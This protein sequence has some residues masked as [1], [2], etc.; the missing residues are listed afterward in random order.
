MFPVSNK[1]VPISILFLAIFFSTVGGQC[2][3][4]CSGNG[5]CNLQGFC[6]CWDGY[7]GWDCSFLGCPSAPAWADIASG[8]DDAHNDAVCSN[9]GYCNGE[10][11][12]CVCHEGF[13]GRACERMS[14]PNDCNG[15]GQCLSM[16]EAAAAEDGNRLIHVA[17]YEAWD[18]DMI[19]GC[20]CDEGYEG[21][22]CSLRPCPVSDSALTSGQ[23]DESVVLFCRC[24][25][26][27]TNTFRLRYKGQYATISPFMSAGEV[28]DRIMAMSSVKSDAREY[29]SPPVVAMFS[30]AAT[31][32]SS[33]GTAA[34]ITFTRDPGDL[35]PVFIKFDKLTSSEGS[36][37][38]MTTEA[39]LV[40]TCVGACGGHFRFVGDRGEATEKLPFSAG[41]SMIQTTLSRLSDLSSANI[42][43][44]ISDGVGS[45]CQDSA[46]VNTTITVDLDYGNY[47]LQIVPSLFDDGQQ[48]QEDEQ[49]MMTL[50]TNDGDKEQE[51]CA[52]LGSCD[53][54][55]G[56]CTCDEDYEYDQEY[57][58][59]GQYVVDHSHWTGRQMCPGFVLRPSFLALGTETNEW[60]LYFTD[61]GDN[62]SDPFTEDDSFDSTVVLPG[63]YWYNELR[64]GETTDDTPDN[65]R[66]MFVN[67]TDN[68]TDLSNALALDMTYRVLY[69]GQGNQV[70]RIPLLSDLVDEGIW[71]AA[72]GT[73]NGLAEAF[74]TLPGYE[75]PGYL[76]MD[77]RP[78]KR[79]LYLTVP[80]NDSVPDGRVLRK[81]LSNDS[82]P[83][84][85]EDLSG[86]IQS[87]MLDLGYNLTDP[88]GIALDLVDEKERQRIYFV[89]AQVRGQDGGEDGV[90][91]RCDLDGTSVE[92]AAS[93]NM[94]DPRAL[95]LDV[96]LAVMY[97]TDTHVPSIMRGSMRNYTDEGIVTILSGVTQERRGELQIEDYY[98]ALTDPQAL[99]L[100]TRLEDL[101]L[102]YFSDYG[103][104]Y[105]YSVE[106]DGNNANALVRMGRPKSFVFDLGEGYPTFTL[107]YD[108]HG[109]GV[110]SGAPYFTCSCDDGWEGN[111][112]QRSCPEGPAWFDEA[113]T[114]GTAHA[115]AECSARG[116][117]D[118]ETGV[119]ACSD[120]FTG[121]ACQRMTCPND[122]NGSGKCL[123]MRQL[124]LLALDS[125][126]VPSPFVYGSTAGNQLTWDA[127]AVYGC[128]CDWMGYQGGGPSYTNL[129]D[130]I[131]YDCSRKSCPTG[132]DRKAAMFNS[133][134]F[135]RQNLTCTLGSGVVN[136]SFSISFRQGTTN[137]MTGNSTLLDLEQALE[138]L[139]TIGDVE[140]TMVGHDSDSYATT[141]LCNSSSGHPASI[142]FKTELGDLPLLSVATSTSSPS[143]SDGTVSLEVAEVTRGTKLD[144]ECSRHG[145]CDYA[146]GECVCFDGWAS[147]DGDGAVGHR[148][149]CGWFPGEAGAVETV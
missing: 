12:L 65:G 43:V 85:Y 17:S 57:G 31:V 68:T 4:Q 34:T 47:P 7:D 110:C 32:C 66:I 64:D 81:K 100:D 6:D 119:C 108:C 111:C 142:V 90:V 123:S 143:S 80:G 46:T 61:G 87:G 72:N 41:E 124:G 55:T 20:V 63:Y 131:G 18:A 33:E 92:I 133:T 60:N 117:C 114:D 122:C 93:Q 89:D 148:R 28:A 116:L 98:Q 96:R 121:D 2:H 99:Q 62:S 74:V 49:P 138:G 147:S 58:P 105:I 22:D 38:H 27:C 15:H 23:Q 145:Y 139:S 83:M 69:Y 70:M 9:M 144:A 30:G 141:M 86:P 52:G 103:T 26:D 1:K 29:T 120:G 78:D 5:E 40:C 126:Y 109:H 94:S 95:V 54:S 59:C 71:H 128:Y 79:Y 82:D 129:S 125:D 77:L 146:E 134:D 16:A 73:A 24:G 76:E 36:N 8:T 104:G 118:R 140:V 137:L 56:Q 10:T 115:Y 112:A 11:G 3:N 113:A 149:D 21:Y 84:G 75:R 130:W 67:A 48:Q 39:T 106:T 37:V 50:T 13:T 97:L 102:L 107:Y 88:L 136:A 35:P 51:Y 44:T 127:D 45:A 25:D 53:F 42:T 101:D 91:I 135:E 19:S 132:D 14:C